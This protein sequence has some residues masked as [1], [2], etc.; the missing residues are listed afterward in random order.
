MSFD[1]YEAISRSHHTPLFTYL[2][3]YISSTESKVNVRIT[4][5]RTAIDSLSTILKSDPSDIIKQELFN[6]LTI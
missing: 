2:G 4:K 6:A 3:S 1:Q 5:V